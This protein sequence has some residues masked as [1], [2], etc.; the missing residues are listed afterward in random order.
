M[1]PPMM[2][3][4]PSCTTTVVSASLV[5]NDG[6]FVAPKLGRRTALTSCRICM[7]TS[8]S[9]LTCGRMVRIFPV[10]RY[11][12][13]LMVAV[14]PLVTTFDA[15]EVRSGFESAARM[16]GWGLSGVLLG[17]RGGDGTSG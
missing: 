9:A 8:P 6:E 17:G 1:I 4:S 12:T 7:L 16:G 13:E 11:W 14:L 5:E 10:S 3:L 2:T 15:V